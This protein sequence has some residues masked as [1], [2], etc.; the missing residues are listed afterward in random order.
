MTRS[1]HPAAA[2]AGVAVLAILVAPFLALAF[3]TRW[4]GFHLAPGDGGAVAVSLG[5]SLVSLGLIAL[6]GTPLAYWLACRQ[7]RGGGVID[8]LVLLPF[9]TPPLAMGILLAALYGPYGPAGQLLERL[10]LVLTNSAPAFVAAQIY[11]AMPYYVVAARAAFA[12]VPAE[13]EE[14]ALTLGKSPWAVFWRV[15]LPLARLGLAAGLATA[16]VRALGEFGIVLIIAY[17]PQGM[18]VKLWVDLQDSGLRAV[19]PLL[20]VFLLVAMPLPLALGIFTRRR[21]A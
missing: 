1:G 12:A 15:S 18:P 21:Y 6:A 2:A 17:F 4:A 8:A 13:Y 10:G 16:W 3:A 7:G 11:G 9:L 20:W 14:I 5:L 19:F